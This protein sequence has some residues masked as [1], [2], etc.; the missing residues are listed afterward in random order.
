MAPVRRVTRTALLCTL[1]AFGAAAQVTSIPAA[2]GSGGGTGPAGPTGSQGATGAAGSA[3]SP[4]PACT[5]TS[6]LTTCTAGSINVASLNLPTANSTS[7][8]LQ[9]FTQAAGTST[10]I[11]STYTITTGSGIVQTVVPL[12]GAAAAG[13]YC[14]A[15]AQGAAGA[16]GAQGVTG[17]SGVLGT[18][19]FTS[20]TPWTMS[21]ADTYKRIEFTGMSAITVATIAPIGPTFWSQYCNSTTQTLTVTTTTP[22]Y[23]AAS[24]STTTGNYTLPAPTAGAN[25]VTVST[26]GTTYALNQSAIGPA[27][28]TGATGPSGANGSAGATGATGPTGA[29]TT[30]ATG[31]TGPS[32]VVASG[33]A[34]L[35]TSAIA[36][37]ACAS[38]VTVSAPGAATS[39]TGSNIIADFSADPTSTTGYSPSANGMLT[40]LKYPTA[41]NVNFKVCNNTASSVTPGAAT[42]N[43]KVI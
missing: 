38:V 4:N 1:L 16:T 30:G 32:S 23:T 22:Y 33:T 26:D 20:T 5:F 31:P 2:T 39:G 37:G 14:T 7:I 8:L 13:G 21:S 28:A 18:T 43:F 35:G 3:A 29:G 25:C 24:G 41:N 9:C 17:P 11:N 12:F 40:I 10:L 36:S 42:L 27:G 34:T 6:T 15:N 19:I